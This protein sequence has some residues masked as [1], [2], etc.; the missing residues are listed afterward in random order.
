MGEPRSPRRSLWRYGVPV[1][2][3]LAG[4]PGAAAIPALPTS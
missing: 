2:C 1:V 3:L 4:M